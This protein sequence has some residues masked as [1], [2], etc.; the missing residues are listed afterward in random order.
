MKKH[1]KIYLK[2][3]Q[4]GIDLIWRCE[5][6][7]KQDRIQNFDIHHI[8]GRGKGMDVIENLMCL[9]RDCPKKAH[10]IANSK[11]IFSNL[12]NEFMRNGKP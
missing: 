9:C 8:H 6:C 4:L 2:F 10:S 5:C 7:N 11:Q 12:H 3:Y 1:V